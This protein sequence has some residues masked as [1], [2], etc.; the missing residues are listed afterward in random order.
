VARGVP[1]RVGVKINLGIAE[2]SG[3][4]EPNDVERSAAWE[5]Y[6]ELITRVTVVPL[7]PDQRP[8][9]ISTVAHER[10]WPQAE[11]LRTELDVTRRALRDYADA[12][13][14]V[15][16]VPNLLGAASG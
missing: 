13:A 9:S 14:L 16:G 2:L 3:E 7:G 15:C 5:L 8:T 6:V 12:L 10:A 1:K 4:W 11:V